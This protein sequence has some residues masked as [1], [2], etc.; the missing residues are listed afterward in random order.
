MQKTVGIQNLRMTDTIGITY[1]SS[2][3][4]TQSKC[5]WD[6]I[7]HKYQMLTR[8]DRNYLPRVRYK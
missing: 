7:K 1:Y 8:F 5:I 2:L 3:W 4:E 6:H